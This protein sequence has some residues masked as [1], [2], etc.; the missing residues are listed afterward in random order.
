MYSAYDGVHT[1]QIPAV[2]N[3]VD[4][5]QVTWSSSD[6]SMVSLATDPITGGTMITV[7]GAGTTTITAQIGDVCGTSVLTIDSATTDAWDAGYSRYHDGVAAELPPDAGGGGHGFNFNPQ[8]ACINCHNSDSTPTP[9]SP[10]TAVSH[11]PEQAGGFSDSDLKGIFLDGNVPDG[12]YFDS[13]IV[14]QEVW[15]SFHQWQMTDDEANGIIV[16]LRSLTPAPQSGT[17][18]FG[19]H[20]YD[21]GHGGH[22]D[23]GNEGDAG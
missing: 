5:S 9:G 8:A 19:G 11:T 3:G 13:T 22:Y 10:F 15:H 18:N 21:G 16:Y 14:P 1:F 6:A 7:N 23:A 20:N 12:G 2:V 17:S 4:Q